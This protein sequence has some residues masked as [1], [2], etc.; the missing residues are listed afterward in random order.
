VVADIRVGRRSSRRNPSCT[1]VVE[2]G[3]GY[4][5]ILFLLH[6]RDISNL[7]FNCAVELKGGNPSWPTMIPS[8]RRLLKSLERIL[9]YE[10]TKGW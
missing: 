9:L 8:P 7:R 1:A 2:F 3:G 10:G 5:P 4:V 6:G